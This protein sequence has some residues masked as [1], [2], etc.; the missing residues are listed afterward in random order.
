MQTNYQMTMYRI[1][2]EID[3]LI[4]YKD[5]EINCLKQMILD[6]FTEACSHDGKYNHKHM[7]TYECAQAFLIENDLIKEKDCE[8]L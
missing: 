2:Q 5:H 1:Q 8:I 7:F 4:K 6:L 3:M